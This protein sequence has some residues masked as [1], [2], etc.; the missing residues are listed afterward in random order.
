MLLDPVMARHRQVTRER[1]DR[2]LAA[3]ENRAWEKAAEAFGEFR[4]TIE[5]HM[6]A[7]ERE[8]FPALDAELGAGSGTKALRNEHSRFRQMC[9][10]IAACIDLRDVQ[11]AAFGLE[12]FG[13]Q[14]EAHDMREE[15]ILF[16][17][18]ERLLSQEQLQALRD[19]LE[20]AG[21]G[22][23]GEGAEP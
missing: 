3:L 7:E 15:W 8:M 21:E 18:C 14:F 10:Y 6:E 20:E 4:H 22:R 23:E 17:M 19:A 13:E 1:L 5:D 11:A 16:P 12:R 9:A 2:V